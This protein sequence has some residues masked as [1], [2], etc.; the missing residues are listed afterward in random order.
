MSHKHLL[1]PKQPVCPFYKLE[2]FANFI[3]NLFWRAK[4]VPVILMELP[5]PGKACIG[6][7]SH[8]NVRTSA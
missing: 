4:Y 8:R 1:K 2:A 5:N 6:M 3:R 7:M